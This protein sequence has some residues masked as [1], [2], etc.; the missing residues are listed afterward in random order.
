MV[1]MEEMRWL[2]LTEGWMVSVCGSGGWEMGT[3]VGDV[4][5]SWD[6]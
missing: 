2:V 4:G 6:A 1:G 5:R 3:Y